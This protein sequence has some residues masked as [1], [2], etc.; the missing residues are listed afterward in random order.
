VG[1]REVALAGLRAAL[2]IGPVPALWAR[3]EGVWSVTGAMF[4]RASV[5]QWLGKLME[6]ERRSRQPLYVQATAEPPP[7]RATEHVVCTLF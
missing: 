5:G 1:S 4:G 3:I 7:D 2:A 6:D